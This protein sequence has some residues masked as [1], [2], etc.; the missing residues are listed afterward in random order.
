MAGRRPRLRPH[1]VRASR[2]RRPSRLVGPGALDAG[3]PLLLAAELDRH[4]RGDRPSSSGSSGRSLDWLIFDAVFTGEN[5]EACLASPDGGA[6]G[7][8]WAFVKAKFGQFIYGRYPIDER[9]RVDIVFVLFAALLM[10]MAIPK[11]P[12]KRENALS[13]ARGLPGGRAGPPDRRQFR[14]QPSTNLILLGILGAVVVFSLLTSGMAETGKQAVP[15][16][17]PRARR[18]RRHRHRRDDRCRSFR[19]G[20]PV[21]LWSRVGTFLSVVTSAAAATARR[22]SRSGWPGCVAIVLSVVSLA[23]IRVRPGRP[24]DFRSL[25]LGPVAVLVL[26]YSS[27]GPISA[28]G[29]SRRRSGAASS[30]RWSCR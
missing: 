1:G 30:S 12:Y 16:R 20:E 18:R 21:A 8:C 7:A 23:T 22:R 25:L 27:S 5:R 26:I 11:V 24:A 10:P 3:K 14:L 13:P 9:W 19:A 6:P 15:A 28:C 2:C 17:S 4:D 29:R